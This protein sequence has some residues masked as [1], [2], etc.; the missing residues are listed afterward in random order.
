ME[1]TDVP[2]RDHSKSAIVSLTRALST[3]VRASLDAVREA[4]EAAYVR[5]RRQTMKTRLWFL[6]GLGAIALGVLAFGPSMAR[7]RPARTHAATAHPSAMVS[8]PV[9]AEAPVKAPAQETIKAPVQEPLEN[10]P[11]AQGAA[12]PR[13]PVA[14]TAD[15]G[16]DAEVVRSTPWLVSP[17]ACMR[18]FES[19]PNNATL[20]LGIAHAEH[21][22]GHLDEAAQWAKRAIALDPHAAEGYILI[23]R[24]EAANGHHEEAR[25]T[26]HKYLEIAPRGWHKAEARA[27]GRRTP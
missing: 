14:A 2:A 17:Q 12:A 22:R 9:A 10:V 11:V 1:Q 21:V 26:Y 18:A 8:P 16:C 15:E 5:S 6:A 23:A 24:A 25:A 4:R 13:S 19:D 7:W 3:E 20:A 27:G